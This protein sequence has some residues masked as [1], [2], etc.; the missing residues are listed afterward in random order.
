M[1]KKTVWAVLLI[2]VVLAMSCS[3]NGEKH[4]QQHIKMAQIALQK[5]NFSEAKL[6]IYSIRLL[7]PKAFEARKGGIRLMQQIDLAEQ[8]RSLAYQDSL[9]VELGKVADVMKQ[10]F[11]LEK[12]TAYQEL[13]IYFHPS[14]VVEKNLYR[15]FLRAQVD[16]RGRMILT[17]IYSGQRNANHH[18]VKVV[19]KDGTF[20]VTPVSE[21]VWQSS[22]L[23]WKTEKADY[24]LGKDGGVVAFIAMNHGLQTMKVEYIGERSYIS[25]LRPADSEAIGQVYKLSQLLSSIE[26]IK[27]DK[28]ETER[29]I[30][31]VE[32]KIKE[33]K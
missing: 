18:A 19:A 15:S 32:R 3:D 30:A 33:N 12:D 17:S 24:P 28:A 8:Q 25:Q 9:L 16:E 7:Y 2:G 20:A 5:K 10:D 27:K 1:R 13:G 22:D 31:F 6:Q 26:E 11:V 14:Q 29:K 23:G 21:D 4:A